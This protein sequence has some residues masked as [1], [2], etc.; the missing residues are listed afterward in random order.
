MEL[1]NLK[2][3]EKHLLRSLKL[4]KEIFDE[5]NRYFTARVNWISDLYIRIGRYSD[6][7]SMLMK[8]ID[9]LEEGDHSNSLVFGE[10][11]SLLGYCLF[12]QSKDLE[13]EGFLVTGYNI[14]KEHEDTSNRILKNSLNRILEFYNS[15]GRSDKVRE[16]SSFL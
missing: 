3:A 5:H 7:E 14:I 9:L 13:A 1:G 4:I 10:S 2:A 6:A 15:K 11:K 12:K 8:Q 16:Y